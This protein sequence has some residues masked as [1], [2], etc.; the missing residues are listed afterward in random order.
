[1]NA[2]KTGDTEAMEKTYAGGSFSLAD[3]FDSED[4]SEEVLNE[5]EEMYKSLV[6]KVVEFDYEV[7]DEEINEETATV[8]VKITTYPFGT[9][10]TEFITE[11]MSQ[12]LTLAFSDASED[13]MD[14]LVTKLYNEK[15]NG[16]TEKT[17]T[18]E[19]SL[20]LN[21]TD[22][23]WKVAEIPADSDFYNALTGNLIKSMGELED[24]YS[25]DE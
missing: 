22:D 6:D 9:A 4:D 24:I 20:K 12:A 10:M 14:K 21:L 8:K 5:D 7:T 25:F 3:A 16:M 1:M 19:T 18:K 13:Q 17:Y 2:I 15:M 11:Y 23:G